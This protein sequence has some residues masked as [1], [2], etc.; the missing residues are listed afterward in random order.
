MGGTLAFALCALLAI[1]SVVAP[2]AA[3][4]GKRKVEVRPGPNAI[5][6]ALDRAD[7]GQ[8][9]R[10]HKGHYDEALTI[11]ERVKLVGVGKRRPVIDAGCGSPTTI[12]VV[13]DGVRLRRLKVVGADPGDEVAFA[14]VSG[15][16]ASNV[17]VRDTCDALYG[18][19]VYDTGPIEIRR[20]R[21]LGFDDAG[22]YIGEIT[23]TGSGAIRLRGSQSYQNHRGLIVENSSGGEIRV[24]RNRF[25]GNNVPV[26][27]FPPTGVLIN[28]SDGVRVEANTVSDNGIFGLLLSS[29]SDGNVIDRNSFFANP[30]DIQNEGSGNCGSGNEF[31][32]GA[33]LPPC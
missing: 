17:V 29:G 3:A 33:P 10:I 18:I 21:A 9:L 23:S 4:N 8:V 31:T 5:A 6:N 16:R 27:F 30:V 32:T 14:E 12:R 25:H 20:S 19:N 22:F 11:D 24:I 26:G 2:S 7:D 28:N 15:G 1:G 13:A